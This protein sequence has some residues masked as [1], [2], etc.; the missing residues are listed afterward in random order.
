MQ[1]EAQV[2]ADFIVRGFGFSR[3]Y[4]VVT[5]LAISLRFLCIS[6]LFRCLLPHP[7]REDHQRRKAKLACKSR[8]GSRKLG[9]SPH[10]TNLRGRRSAVGDLS[11]ELLFLD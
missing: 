8:G 9:G 10:R 3:D 5:G 11:C 7:E 6:L 2:Q 4:Q 1:S